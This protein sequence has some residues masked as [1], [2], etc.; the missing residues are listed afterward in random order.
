VEGLIGFFVNTL[1]LRTDLGGNPSFRELI[2]RER[3]VALG[4]YAHQ[5]AP[6]E[7]LVEEINPERD[8]SRSP[9]FQ[10][11]MSLQNTSQA[12]L[13]IRDL[14]LREVGEEAG[15]AKFDLELMLTE[16]GEEIVGS[17][18]YS[19]DLYEAET[20]RRMARH[21]EHVLADAVRDAEQRV[22]EIEL[23]DA[24]EKR[25]ILEE[26]NATEREYGEPRLVHEMIAEQARRRGEMIAVISEQ[27]ALSYGELNRR[28]NRLANYLGSRGVGCEDLV[29][30]C[31]ERSLEMVIAILGVLKAGAAYVPIDTTDPGQRVE[32]TLVD[33]EV[34][35]LLTQEAVVERLELKGQELV[36]LDREWEQIEKQSSEE[37]GVRVEVGGLAY[38]IYTSGST[39]KPKGAMNTHGGIRNRLLWMQ[40]QYGLDET[41]RVLQKTTFSFD[42]SVWEFVWPLMRGA[43]L[44]MARPGGHK[45]GGYLLGVIKEEEITTMHF[46]PSMLGV[47]LEE[48]V[49]EARSLRR[50]ICSGEALPRE[51]EERTRK[52]TGAEVSNLYGPTEAAIDVTYWICAGEGGGGW[53]PIGKPIANTEMYVLDGGL[54]AAPVGVKGEIYIGGAGLARGY[55]RRAEMTAE[56]FV[57]AR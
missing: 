50:V 8:L 10:V 15:A 43:A 45:D 16:S 33:A 11:M 9:L 24:A 1:V 4:A 3:E 20:I 37:P 28:A 30:I 42:V 5:E 19:Q 29:G 23:M 31:A 22:H 49:E 39:G 35:L 48:R 51:L 54:E 32:G 7:K 36:C 13:E 18:T 26:W 47:F 41:D 38:V 53:A 6:F 40:E 21:F 44:V 2:G 56:R 14:K 34:K 17:L 52:R 27:G 46:V 57:P 25:Q 12:E 55:L